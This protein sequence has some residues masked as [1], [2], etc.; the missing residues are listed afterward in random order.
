VAYRI[1]CQCGKGVFAELAD[2]GGRL[3]CGCGRAVTVPMR[4][5]LLRM[6]PTAR[7]DSPPPQP[8]AESEASRS[9]N[10]GLLTILVGVGLLFAGAMSMSWQKSPGLCLDVFGVGAIILGV[11]RLGRGIL[12]RDGQK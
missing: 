2:A 9:R 5:H 12:A 7:R 8:P 11:W 1:A 6:P 10:S 4:S 3:T